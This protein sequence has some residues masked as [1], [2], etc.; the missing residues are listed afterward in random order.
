M[1]VAVAGAGEAS[2]LGAGNG[3]RAEQ[4]QAGAA[5][6]GKERWRIPADS[7]GVLGLGQMDEG[8]LEDRT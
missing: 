1:V 3:R 2:G 4:E 8:R 7:F 6:D 5:I